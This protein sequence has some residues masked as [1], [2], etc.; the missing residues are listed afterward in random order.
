LA[1]G[2]EA[3]VPQA[4]LWYG[5]HVKIPDGSTVTM[6]DTAEN[7]AV[8]PQQTGQQQGLGF[9]IARILV[10]FS[11]ASGMMMDLEI[12]PYTG[13]ETGETALL[14]NLSETFQGGDVLL[15]DSIFTSYFMIAL[16][17]ERGIDFVGRQ[18]QARITD[19][20]RGERLGHCD[21]VV[22]WQRPDRPAWMDRETYDRMPRSLRLRELKVQVEQAGFRPESF[23]VVTTLTDAKMYPAADIADLYRQRWHAEL[24]LRSLKQTLG[25]DVLRSKSPEMVC[26][27]IRTHMLAY[28][29]IRQT[30]LQAMRRSEPDEPDLVPIQLSFT[31]A[32]Q[33][34]AASWEVV[35]V[36]D[37]SRASKLIDIDLDHIASHRVGNRPDRV[38]PRAVK[39]RPKPHRLL[40]MTREE[41]RE[42]LG[43]GIDPY[44]KQ[45]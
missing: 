22:E 32:M 3:Q 40:T 10:V 2:C 30:M 29:L 11:L 34:I 8:F 13:K 42:L 14:R 33:K 9:P 4:W 16:L 36:F 43:R 44:E 37:T 38:E 45:K 7:Q 31:A 21:H 27:E 20:R 26:K 35:L 24:D 19:F 5:R 41:A 12:G 6:P 25:M 15:G 23:V 17:G 18:H 1:S 39:R 28:N